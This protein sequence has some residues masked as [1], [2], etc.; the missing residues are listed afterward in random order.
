MFTINGKQKYDSA[1]PSGRK[2]PNNSASTCPWCAPVS[3]VFQ[4]FIYCG[5]QNQTQYSRCRFSK[6]R[7]FCERLRVL[8]IQCTA[9]LLCHKEHS[10]LMDWQVL[11]C[12]AAFH[13]VC[14]QLVQSHEVI[15]CQMQETAFCLV[16]LNKLPVSLFLPP[17]EFPLN[18]TLEGS[19]A[20]H[21]A[22]PLGF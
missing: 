11:F 10:P 9:D 8:T 4:S 3:T 15:S 18:S 19:P 17:F 1:L 12:K 13:L 5:L 7:V 20:L 22:A 2:K 6:V 16:E 21:L 14:D